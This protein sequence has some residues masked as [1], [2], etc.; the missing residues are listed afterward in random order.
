MLLEI[1]GLQR[2]GFRQAGSGETAYAV[3]EPE[4]YLPDGC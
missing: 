4:F 2:L 3:G 1:D